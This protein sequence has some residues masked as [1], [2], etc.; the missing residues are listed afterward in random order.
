MKVCLGVNWETA[1]AFLEPEILKGNGVECLWVDDKALR[2][3]AQ[4]RL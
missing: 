4:V 1:P 2:P 3:I